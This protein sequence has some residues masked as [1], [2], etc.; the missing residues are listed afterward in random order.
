MLVRGQPG[1]R[2][3][4]PNPPPEQRNERP[5]NRERRG[6]RLPEELKLSSERA[7][8]DTRPTPLPRLRSMAMLSR[9]WP[10]GRTWIT[11]EVGSPPPGWSAQ[12][13]PTPRCG[14]TH[15]RRPDRIPDTARIR[16]VR[17]RTSRIRRHQTVHPS[18]AGIRPGTCRGACATCAS[19]RGGTEPRGSLTALHSRSLTALAFRWSPS[20]AGYWSRCC[21]YRRRRGSCRAFCRRRPGCRS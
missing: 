18:R 9:A 16:P 2:T 17:P 11:S 19:G 3:H 1:R 8:D 12:A 4:R 15:Q 13:R 10:W 7:I 14:R 6:D 5:S 20:S 21:G